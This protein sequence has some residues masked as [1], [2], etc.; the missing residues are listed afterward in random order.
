MKPNLLVHL[1]ASDFVVIIECQCFGGGSKYQLMISRCQ[2]EL[3]EP[4]PHLQLHKTVSPLALLN[5][6]ADLAMIRTS[7]N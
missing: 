4:S 5:H 3:G 1:L 7:V 6:V 2:S